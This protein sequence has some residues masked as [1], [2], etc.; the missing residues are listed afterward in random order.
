MVEMRAGS[1]PHR[2]RVLVVEDD[3]IIVDL[4]TDIVGSCGYSV[5]VASCASEAIYALEKQL[6]TAACVILDYGIPGMDPSRLLSRMREIQGDLKVLLSS[7]YSR[8]FIDREFALDSVEG[9][10]AKPYEPQALQE[11]LERLL[12]D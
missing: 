11:E 8:A 10:L 3:P 1:T 9:F 2:T 5:E 12:K 7:G 4:L 6:S